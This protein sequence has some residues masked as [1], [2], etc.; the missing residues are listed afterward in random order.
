VQ[1][2]WHLTVDMRAQHLRSRGFAV[3]KLD[4]RGSARRGLAFEGAL[5]GNMGDIEVQ[6]QVDGVRRLVAQGIADPQ[7]VGIYGW[8]YGGYM[9]L[10]ALARA[11]ET[12]RAGA[13]GAPVT[14]WDTYDT[15]YTER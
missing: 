10:M 5:R 11:P 8:S 1:S 7:R 13:A 4:N 2:G 14:H 12:F 9:S 3:L 6:D 15:H